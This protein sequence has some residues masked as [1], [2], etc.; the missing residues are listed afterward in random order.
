MA[1]FNFRISSLPANPGIQT[2]PG[3]CDSLLLN[4]DRGANVRYIGWQNDAI[5]CRL[6]FA[7]INWLTGAASRR[8]RKTEANA[9]EIDV[10]SIEWYPSSWSLPL[11][12]ESRLTERCDNQR[13]SQIEEY[14][15]VPVL[16]VE[17]KYHIANSSS[18]TSFKSLTI[19]SNPSFGHLLPS[20]KAHQNSPKTYSPACFAFPRRSLSF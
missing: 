13:A 3:R 1:S 12:L 19:R 14:V 7:D 2:V 11:L 15:Q 5:G 9:D 16:I 4:V 18:T 8:R 17:R 10:G 6:S 20:H